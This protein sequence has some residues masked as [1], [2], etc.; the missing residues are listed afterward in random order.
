MAKDGSAMLAPQGIQLAV[1][2]SAKAFSL[3][4]RIVRQINFSQLQVDHG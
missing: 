2:R 3:G 4:L 1:I